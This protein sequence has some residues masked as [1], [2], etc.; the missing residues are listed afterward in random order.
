MAEKCACQQRGHTTASI[1]P[2]G[3][4][5]P[6]AN[7][8]DSTHAAASIYGMPTDAPLEQS[9]SS[10]MHNRVVSGAARVTARMSLVALAAITACEVPT[11]LP[12]WDQTWLIPGDSTRVSVSEL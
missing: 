2:A 6:S 4:I 12:S 8:G 1:Q 10:F 11:K 7:G 5:R 9:R 3:V